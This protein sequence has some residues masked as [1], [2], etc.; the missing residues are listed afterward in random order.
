VFSEGDPA[1]RMFFLLSGRVSVQLAVGDHTRRLASIGPGAAF[2]EM[3]L[4]DEGRRSSTVVADEDVVCRAL[5]RHAL[6]DLE[7][8][9]P[10]E[11]ASVL[12]RNLAKSLSGRLLETNETVRT[13]E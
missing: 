8:G 1:D 2:G 13:L 3:A 9:P 7:D 12:F 11:I 10:G 6:T 4:L 5:S